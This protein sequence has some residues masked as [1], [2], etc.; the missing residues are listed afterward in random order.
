MTEL[1]E[2][3][4]KRLTEENAHMKDLLHK[5]EAQF[6][7]PVTLCFDLRSDKNVGEGELIGNLYV[8]KNKQLSG[9][10]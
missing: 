8:L 2:K 9:M 10:M 7:K 5:E 6:C 3:N 4:V 1:E